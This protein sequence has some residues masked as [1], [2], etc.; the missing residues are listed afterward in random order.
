MPVWGIEPLLQADANQKNTN[1]GRGVGGKLPGAQFGVSHFPKFLQ[2][3]IKQ[4]VC[5]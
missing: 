3:P 5:V 2:L 1:P 4:G